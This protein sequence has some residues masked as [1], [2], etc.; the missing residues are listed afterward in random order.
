MAASKRCLFRSGRVLGARLR[1]ITTS[2][3]SCSATGTGVTLYAGIPEIRNFENGGG[4]S[5]EQI[6]LTPL[7]S[8]RLAFTTPGSTAYDWTV[9]HHD[10]LGSVRRV[11]N[12]AGVKAEGTFDRPFGNRDGVQCSLPD[13]ERAWIPALRPRGRILTVRIFESSTR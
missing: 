10:A 4:T 1:K 8:I 11:A 12:S 6:F 3:T 13:P 5:P 9:I 2:A 7:P